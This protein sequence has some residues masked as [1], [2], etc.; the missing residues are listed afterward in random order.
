MPPH[1]R[2][3][4]QSSLWSGFAQRARSGKPTRRRSLGDRSRRA[5]LSFVGL[6]SFRLLV[7]KVLGLQNFGASGNIWLLIRKGLAGC[8][9]TGSQL[10]GLGGRGKKKTRGRVA[11]VIGSQSQP[12]LPRAIYSI[13]W[14]G[15]EAQALSLLSRQKPSLNRAGGRKQT[16][17]W[18]SRQTGRR[19]CRRERARRRTPGIFFFLFLSSPRKRTDAEAASFRLPQARSGGRAT[20]GGAVAISHPM[21]RRAEKQETGSW[22]RRKLRC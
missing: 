7:K 6:R 11:R 13:N 19:L 15:E 3:R 20:D 16:L 1:E 12:P 14:G 4:A 18:A 2:R 21:T 17:R 8:A 10:S 22:E 5:F 9:Q